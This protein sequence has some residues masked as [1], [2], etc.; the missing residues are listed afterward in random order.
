MNQHMARAAPAT[1][2]ESAAASTQLPGYRALSEASVNVSSRLFAKM[3][4]KPIGAALM[5]APHPLLSFRV[6]MPNCRLLAKAERQVFPAVPDV[7][8]AD[9]RR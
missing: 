4:V 2:L 5:T 9:H 1:C 3:F 7:C 6:G 8:V